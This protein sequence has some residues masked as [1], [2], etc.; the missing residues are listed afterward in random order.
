ML[1]PSDNSC[2]VAHLITDLVARFFPTARHANRQTDYARSNEDERE[3]TFSREITS[4]QR[5]AKTPLA[6]FPETWNVL[7]RV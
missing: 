3:M 2:T 1:P 6:R 7:A 5:V 4:R